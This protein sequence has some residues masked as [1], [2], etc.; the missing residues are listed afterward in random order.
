MSSEE[1]HNCLGRILMTTELRDC[2]ADLVIEA[3]IEQQQA[4]TELFNALAAINFPETILPLILLRFLLHSWPQRSFIPR[5]WPACI[6][7]TPH[8]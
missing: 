2:V 5:A 1:K 8:P 6:S 7:S 4:K 3:I